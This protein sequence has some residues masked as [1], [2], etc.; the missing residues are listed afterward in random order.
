M[1]DEY[2]VG[3]HLLVEDGVSVALAGITDQL[4]AADQ[5]IAATAANWEGLPSNGD[6]PRSPILQ[7]PVSAVSGPQIEL[8]QELPSNPEAQPTSRLEPIFVPTVAVSLPVAPAPRDLLAP[9]LRAPD[10]P[11]SVLTSA[12]PGWPI[13]PDMLPPLT[14]SDPNDSRAVYQQTAVSNTPQIVPL[15]RPQNG[16][17]GVPWPLAVAPILAD[18]IGP[19]ISSISP[20]ETSSNSALASAPFAPMIV[21]QSE[22]VAPK[23]TVLAGPVGSASDVAPAGGAAPD[24]MSTA[25]MADADGA[26]GQLMLDGSLLGRWVIDHLGQ[27]ADRAPVGGVAF[28]PRQARA[29][30]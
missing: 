14:N 17:F 27:E 22:S 24:A 19:A 11:L 30:A 15:Q 23:D 25:P 10:V 18:M 16:E 5:A 13:A 1:D 12:L 8:P 21:P 29:W 3:V 6:L 20:P 7:E 26:E 4:A 9:S 2:K 28:D